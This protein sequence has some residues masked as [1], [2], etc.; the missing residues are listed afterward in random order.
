MINSGIMEK[1]METKG[2]QTFE[3]FTGKPIET[4]EV[5]GKV[6]RK[7]RDCRE[8]KELNEDNFYKRETENGWRGRCRECHNKR[9][10]VRQEMSPT[11][12]AT[13]KK[14]RDKY[15]KEKP[16]ETLL[17]NAR[18][19]AKRRYKDFDLKIDR[20]YELWE[21]QKGLCYY[22]GKPMGYQIGLPDSV[23]LDRKDSSIGYFPNN[24]VLCRYKVNIVKND[25]SIEDLLEFCTDV[26]TNFKQL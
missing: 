2:V 8:Y 19:N 26:L 10:R 13:G 14:Y 7:C 22:T 21:E 9:L 23:S 16:L 5:E 15:K 4:I 6:F 12:L 18:G 24:V 25:L 20:L 17:K 3:S 11:E 1:N